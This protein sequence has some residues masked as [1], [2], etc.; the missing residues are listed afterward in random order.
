MILAVGALTLCGSW[1]GCDKPAVDEQ[2]GAP[3][4]GPAPPAT[5]EDVRKAAREFYASREIFERPVAYHSVPAG[6]PDVK[7]STCGSCHR[8]IY[9]EWRIS[10]HARAWLDDVQFQKE[11]AKARG[12]HGGKGDVGWMCV[13]CHTPTE[14]QLERLVVGLEGGAIDKPIYA[15]NPVFDRD[16]QLD[17]IG[18]ATCHVRDAKVLGPWGD[19][20]APHAV[21]KGESLLSEEVC[22]RCH[23]AE[24]FYESQNLGCFFTTGEE[25]AASEYAGANRTCQTCHMPEVERPIAIGSKPRTTRRHWFGGSLIPKKP[26]YEA[27]LAPLREVYG[28]G[29]TLT[30]IEPSA[31]QIRRASE[32]PQL[33]E[34]DLKIGQALTLE[35]PTDGR[36]LAVRVVNDRAGHRI[37]TGDPERHVDVEVIAREGDRIVARSWARFGSRYEWWPKTRLLADTRLAPGEDA[38]VLLSVP[39]DRELEV[40]VIATKNRMYPEAFAYHEL[41]GKYVRGREFHRSVWTVKPTAAPVLRQTGAADAE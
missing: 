11:L 8:E 12:E 17:A 24:R 31:D 22:T 10:T 6:L 39:D 36:H 29:V 7:S 23:Q 18:C 33:A 30:V 26:E 1:Q 16:Q 15:P 4:A 27:E 37:P 32:R 41:E 13:N 35:G 9:E 21:A 3:D 40:E 14:G 19:T 34:A 2:V 5:G 20:A 28:D 25:W 38:L